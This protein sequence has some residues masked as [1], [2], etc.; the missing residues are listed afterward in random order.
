[1][2]QMQEATYPPGDLV[3]PSDLAYAMMVPDFTLWLYGVF[4]YGPRPTFVRGRRSYRR[5]DIEFWYRPGDLSTEQRPLALREAAAELG[6]RPY[7]LYLWHMLGRGP[8]ASRRGLRV[9]YDQETVREW[10]MDGW[11]SRCLPWGL[12]PS[13]EL[14][15]P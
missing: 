14:P 9:V 3:S 6:V 1:M 4:G 11:V 12:M 10:G 5:V 13:L 8:C 7:L 15:E 2:T